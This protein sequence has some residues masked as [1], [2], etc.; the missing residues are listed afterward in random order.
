MTSNNVS[1]SE[2]TEPIANLEA[3]PIV[4][5]HYQRRFVETSQFKRII[6]MIVL[7]TV[8]ISGWV[9]A[10]CKSRPP[11]SPPIVV[12]VFQ[13]PVYTSMISHTHEPTEHDE[14]I[15]ICA[16]VNNQPNDLV[17]WFIH[18]YHHHGIRYFY[19]MDDNSIPPL[20]EYRDYGIPK[21][22]ITFKHYHPNQMPPNENKQQFLYDQCTKLYGERHFWIGYLDVDEYIEVTSKD[23]TLRSFLQSFEAHPRVGA[24]VMN[25]YIHTS[26]GQL[27]RPNSTRKAFVTCISDEEFPIENAHVKSFV[28]PIYYSKPET[29]HYF[30]TKYPY[31]SVGEKGDVIQGSFRNYITRDRIT[32]HHYMLKSKEEYAEK[33]E[34]GAA[35]GSHRGW[36][37]WKQ[38][39]NGTQVACGNLASYVP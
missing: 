6:M 31:V 9:F 23:E 35:D 10:F 39:E 27:T 34:R 18:H 29:P 15:A 20:S 26:S 2:E 8:T 12:P 25:W 3:S 38:F 28:R 4:I 7:C 32:V 11:P 33:I 24:V 16:V 36:D 17:E 30:F 5:G 21:E 14:Y 13:E 1:D 19:I 22:A 37:Q